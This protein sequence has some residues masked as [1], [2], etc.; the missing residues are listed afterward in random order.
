MVQTNSIECL[1]EDVQQ[2][3]KFDD[4]YVY[5]DITQD[6]INGL[7]KDINDTLHEILQKELEY[8]KTNDDRLW[9]ESHEEVKAQS[10]YFANL[11]GYSAN[12]HLPYKQY[13]DELDKNK[14]V[15]VFS[16]VGAEAEDNLSW[17]AEL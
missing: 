16:G 3:F 11:S 13:L 7:I 1:P 8:E 5:V 17:L 12:L 14:N 4:C 6:L 10:Y 2:K 15:D 9:W